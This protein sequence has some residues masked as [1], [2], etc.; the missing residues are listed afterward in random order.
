MHQKIVS[1]ICVISLVFGL[2]AFPLSAM[3][4][5]RSSA[6]ATIGSVAGS[7]VFS[8]FYFPIRMLTC[9]GTQTVTAPTYWITGDVPGNFKGGT[10]R[11]EISEVSKGACTSSWVVT[12]SD[13][14]RDYRD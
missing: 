11:K 12:P 4:Q 13:L 14:R 10:N 5:E 6:G 2:L 9:V 7:F 1:W 3:A 8:L